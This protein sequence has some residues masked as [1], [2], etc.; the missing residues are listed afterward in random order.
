[1]DAKQ[2]IM[3]YSVPPSADDLEAMA[4]AVVEGLPEELISGCEDLVVSVEEFPDE[5]TEQE[6]EL[7]DPYELL[8]LFRSG[9]EIS[10]GVERKMADEDDSLV[11]FRRPFLDLWCESGD[12]LTGLLH[13]VIAEELGKNFNFS[14]DEIDEIAEQLCEGAL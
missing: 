7:E 4:A 1:M 14:E 6:L 10:P 5:A 3:N 12:D 9:K 8:V 2:I 13:Q 11:I